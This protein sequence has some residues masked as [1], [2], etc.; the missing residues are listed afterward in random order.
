M[1]VTDFPFVR[2]WKKEESAKFWALRFLASDTMY[3]M[4]ELFRGSIRQE[5]V[6]ISRAG[7]GRSI[8]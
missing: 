7:G 1:A 3:D 2:R 8:F 6:S 5:E 4:M